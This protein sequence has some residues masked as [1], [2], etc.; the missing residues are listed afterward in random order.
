M[1]RRQVQLL[2]WAETTEGFVVISINYTYGP[3]LL[4]DTYAVHSSVAKHHL[5]RHMKYVRW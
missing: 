3:V 2:Y 1:I 5:P 4:Y